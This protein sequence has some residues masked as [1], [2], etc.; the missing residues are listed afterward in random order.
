MN[1]T[2]VRSA[3]LAFNISLVVFLLAPAS[4][5]AFGTAASLSPGQKAHVTIAVVPNGTTT[6]AMATIDGAAVG[7]LSPGLG[8]VPAEQTWLDLGQGSRT[9]DST[10]DTVLDPL[11]ISRN[12]VQNWQSVVDRAETATEPVIPG[13]LASTLASTDRIT[14]AGDDL[15]LPSIAAAGRRG[16]FL[17]AP[18]GCPGSECRAA[19]TIDDT[20]I[21]GA[22][23]LAEGLPVGDLLIVIEDPP[24]DPGDQLSIAVAGRGNR[25]MLSSASTRTSGYVLT[26]DIAPTII[27][28]FGI[29][30]PKEM[31]GLPITSAGDI[32]FGRLDNLEG[33]Y[34]QV[35]KRRGAAVA[36]PILIWLLLTGA[37]ALLTRG[38]LAPAALKLLCLSA[39][40]LPLVLLLIASVTPSL[41]VER[42]VAT[43][44]PVLAGALL[45]RFL[46]GYRALAAACLVTVAAYGVDMVAG[47]V[48]TPRA[49]IGPNPGLGARFYGIG[50][51][52]ESTLMILTSVGIGALASSW[53]ALREPDRAAVAFVAAGL[54]G[55]IVFG[56]GRFGADVGAVIIFPVAAAIAAATVTG[57]PGLAWFGGLAALL[58]LVVVGLAD[59]VLG[60]ETHFVRAVLGA[61]S[62]DSVFA[63]FSHR[64]DAT[65]ESF[66]RPSRLPFTV[67]ALGLAL[68]GYVKRRAINGWLE[69]VPALRAGI[70]AAA[71]TS[72]VGV[73]C[74]DSGALFIQVG[75]LFIS[76]ILGYSWAIRA[77]RSDF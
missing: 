65:L 48:L 24:V 44:A 2:K 33:R 52:L 43:I 61:G 45:L 4:V 59:V 54:V 72:V 38:R 12:K 68:L 1:L 16:N 67:L 56:A 69:D 9:F 18:P 63:V 27:N 73:V 31:T 58:A 25:G 17:R 26:T 8:G 5:L 13:L 3:I 10:Y 30:I 37:A 6:R 39:I 60:A 7:L 77:H 76:V 75:A 28:L 36:V 46:P 41:A 51:E 32:D 11:F 70:I 35:G 22:R 55:T 49:V 57:R 19:L 74:N 34:E 42:A 47:S 62:A 14:L 64:L 29:A 53:A 21:G 50:N 20:T 71:A 15:G 23:D 66:T 40:L